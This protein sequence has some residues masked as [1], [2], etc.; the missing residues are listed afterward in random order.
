M[1]PSTTQRRAPTTAATTTTA[2]TSPSPGSSLT[3]TAAVATPSNSLIRTLLKVPTIVTILLRVALWP[4]FKALNLIFPAK[5][6]DG[7]NNTAA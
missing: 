7:V 5:E 1:D 2:A 4:L 6:F 3:Q